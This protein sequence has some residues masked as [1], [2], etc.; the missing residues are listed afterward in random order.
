MT[1]TQERAKQGTRSLRLTA[2]TFIGRL[3]QEPVDESQLI[4][5]FEPGRPPGA[6][7][8]RRN[9]DADDW[10][11]YNRLSFWV[12]PTLPGFRTLL[13]SSTCANCWTPEN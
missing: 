9:F 10:S 1:F 4:H 3:D 13:S 7:I 12:Y 5:S 6:A 2:P 11:D 8:A